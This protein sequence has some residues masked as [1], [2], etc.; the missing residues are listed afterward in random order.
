V[1]GRSADMEKERA[2]KILEGIKEGFQSV[3]FPFE[4]L[5]NEKFL[6]VQTYYMAPEFEDVKVRIEANI[7]WECKGIEIFNTS[8]DAVSP[9]K[10]LLADELIHTLN[11]WSIIGHLFR[12]RANRLIYLA[13]IPLGDVSFDKK[14][15]EKVLRGL[16]DT[17]CEFLNFLE[18]QLKSNEDPNISLQRLLLKISKRMKG[19]A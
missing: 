14:E 18:K 6:W 17:G 19:R 4:E 16:I 5:S 2:Y 1:K 13:G 11:G 9:D 3:G 12:D 8:V 7:D 10:I 15:F